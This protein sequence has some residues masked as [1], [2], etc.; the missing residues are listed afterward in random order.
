[1]TYA[2]KVPDPFNT[3]LF[4]P[5]TLANSDYKI[6]LQVW[7]MRLGPIMNDIIGEHQRGFIPGRD[8]REN[9]IVMQAIADRL[10][11]AKEGGIKL[12][13]IKFFTKKTNFIF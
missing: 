7:A 10:Y 3:G 12:V 9:I 4:R 8:G 13:F 1:M 2:P 6:I 5:I 11:K